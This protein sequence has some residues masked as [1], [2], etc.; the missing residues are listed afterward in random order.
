VDGEEGEKYYYD[1]TLQLNEQRLRDSYV[2]VYM[3][4]KDCVT[5]LLT[6]ACVHGGRERRD[7]RILLMTML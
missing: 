4:L 7:E 6:A 3:D 2:R 5:S 1:T